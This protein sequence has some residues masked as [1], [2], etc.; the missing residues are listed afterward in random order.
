MPEGAELVTTYDRLGYFLDAFAHNEIGLLIIVGPPGPGKSTAV[1]AHLG[2]RACLIKGGATPYRLYQKLYEHRDEPIVLDDADKIFRTQDGMFLFKILCDTEPVKW[3]QWNSATPE[4]RQGLLPDTF[5]TTSR[6]V[7]IANSWPQT[8]PDIRAVESRGHLMYFSPP[9]DEMHRYAAAWVKD[10]EVYDFV[11]EHL[12]LMEQ[13]DLRIYFKA[14]ERKRIGQRTGHVGEWKDFVRKQLL[15][16]PKLVAL[17]L[18]M[19]PSFAS[20]HRRAQEYRRLTGQSE[21]TFYR[22]ATELAQRLGRGRN[23]DAGEGG[24]IVS[25]WQ[26]LSQSPVLALRQGGTTQ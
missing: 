2:R 1:A 8:N 12:A 14:Q 13:P 3:P 16:G 4:I 5:P 20:D 26:G 9:A 10:R 15:I 21:R 7:V 18:L 22:Q 17:Q 11:G 25:N 24:R 23:A 6:V 19:D